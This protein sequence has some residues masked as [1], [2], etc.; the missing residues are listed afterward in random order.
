M[1][2]SVQDLA[3]GS[4]GILVGVCAIAALG[5]VLG[6]T[7]EPRSQKKKGSG[8]EDL[9]EMLRAQLQSQQNKAQTSAMPSKGLQN[10]TLSSPQQRLQQPLASLVDEDDELD[11]LLDGNAVRAEYAQFMTLLNQQKYEQAASIGRELMQS[12]ARSEGKSFEWLTFVGDMML[13]LEAHLKQV[14]RINTLIKEMIAALEAGPKTL[15]VYSFA[16][17]I[18]PYLSVLSEPEQHSFFFFAV[19]EIPQLMSSLGKLNPTDMN[20]LMKP[21]F[22]TSRL[23][24]CMNAIELSNKL[25]RW[26]ILDETIPPIIESAKQLWLDK[27]YSLIDSYCSALHQQGRTLEAARILE[28]YVAELEEGLTPNKALTTIISSLSRASKFYFYVDGYSTSV[29]LLEK[30]ERLCS[31]NNVP[32][33]I[34]DKLD[35]STAYREAGNSSQADIVLSQVL[36]SAQ[37]VADITAYYGRSKYLLTVGYKL[38]SSSLGFQYHLSLKICRSLPNR[39][40]GEVDQS[41]D[42]YLRKIN[43]FY[44]VVSFENVEGGEPLALETEVKHY[45][46][47]LKSPAF[48]SKPSTGKWYLIKCHLFSNCQKEQEIGYHYQPVRFD[49]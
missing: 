23:N 17:K 44:L 18:Y 19:G 1:N 12:I 28:Q 5:Y 36:E 24:L 39:K 45:D 9:M 15:E 33:K 41:E 20:T 31:S 29:S 7:E 26:K 34:K 14:S 13:P 47:E 32:F 11:D 21:Q 37:P 6:P 48:S 46:V 8:Q 27:L 30:I 4:A 10:Q 43:N 35:L 2:L 3:L 16:Y 49:Q 40:E 25:G 42:R 22:I 38:L